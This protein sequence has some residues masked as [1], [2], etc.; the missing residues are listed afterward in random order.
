MVEKKIIQIN[1]V[2][3]DFNWKFPS[4]QISSK[5]WLYSDF[6]EFKVH[7]LV[8]SIPNRRHYLTS[9]LS[10]WKPKLFNFVTKNFFCQLKIW[11][12]FIRK[13]KSHS[14]KLIKS[15]YSVF[16]QTNF[17]NNL[18]YHTH[19]CFESLS[20]ANFANHPIECKRVRLFVF[21][22]SELAR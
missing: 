10:A 8:Y 13:L 19:P 18:I 4:L 15:N 14:L 2:Q 21:S 22:C 16:P 17:S 9:Q 3:Q 6:C 1:W 12:A 11:K 7:S 5:L 20:N